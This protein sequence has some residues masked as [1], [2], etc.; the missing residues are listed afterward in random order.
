[1]PLSPN[2]PQQFAQ[3]GGF[4]RQAQGGNFQGGGGGG[5][6]GFIRQSQG[7]FRAPLSLRLLPSQAEVK[8]VRTLTLMKIEPS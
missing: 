6:G 5:G 2:Y 7:G 1:M 8:A 3:T 4:I